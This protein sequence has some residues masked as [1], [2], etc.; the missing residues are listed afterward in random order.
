MSLRDHC[1]E[2]VARMCFVKKML[3]KIAHNSQ[4]TIV[5]ESFLIK[6]QAKTC[7]LTKKENLEQVFFCEFCEKF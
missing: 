3:K 1:S 7:D 2:P 4:K 5:P 6:L